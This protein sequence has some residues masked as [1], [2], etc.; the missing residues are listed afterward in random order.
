[1]QQWKP[2]VFM[3]DVPGGR[4]EHLPDELTADVSDAQVTPVT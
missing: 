3:I 4:D 1:M 2:D